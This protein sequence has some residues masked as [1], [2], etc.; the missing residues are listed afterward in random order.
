MKSTIYNV[1]H[2][3]GALVVIALAFSC[4]VPIGLRRSE[5]QTKFSHGTGFATPQEAV[6]A[7][8]QMGQSAVPALAEALKDK[9]SVVRTNAAQALK[10]IGP[11]A[12]AAAPALVEALNDKEPVVRGH[13]AEVLGQIGELAVPALAKALQDK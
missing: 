12:Q 4:L 1:K 6:N 3:I 9:N 8:V 7:L 5:A 13:A 10:K 2:S 11:E